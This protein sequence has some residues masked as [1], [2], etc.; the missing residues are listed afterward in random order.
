MA[1]AGSAHFGLV[2][3]LLA[4]Q[5]FRVGHSG[6]LVCKKKVSFLFLQVKTLKE[7]IEEEKGKDHFSVAGL[8]LIYAGMFSPFLNPTNSLFITFLP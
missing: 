8:K 1:L 5:L 6:E 7:R 3:F 4:L 2:L